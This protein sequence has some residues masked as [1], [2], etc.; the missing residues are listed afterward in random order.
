MV[1]IE[2]ELTAYDLHNRKSTKK[3]VKEFETEKDFKAD[4]KKRKRAPGFIA[5]KFKRLKSVSDGSEQIV[6]EIMKLDEAMAGTMTKID[7]KSKPYAETCMR[8][9][10]ERGKLCK[11]LEQIQDYP[12]KWKKEKKDI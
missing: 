2:Y 1:K 3:F 9:S 6:S 11:I 7:S 12:K 10:F 8:L 4:L 5:I